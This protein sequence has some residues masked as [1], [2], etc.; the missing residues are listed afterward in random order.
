MTPVLAPEAEVAGLAAEEERAEAAPVTVHDRRADAAEE[1][2]RDIAAPEPP[3]TE[4]PRTEPPPPRP[5]APVPERR[6]GGAVG[7]ILGGIVAGAIGFG[8]AW[9]LERMNDPGLDITGEFESRDAL[10]AA[11]EA[12][13][14]DLRAATADGPDLTPLE[15]ATESAA[16]EAAA[17]RAAV[18]ELRGDIAESVGSL[19]DGL[20][21]LD[22]RLTDLEQLPQGDGSLSSAAVEAYEREIAALRE[23]TAEAVSGLEARAGA[24]ETGFDELRT[25]VEAA[26]AD[27]EAEAEA[28]E[29]QSEEA[30]AAAAART[31]LAEIQGAVSGGAPYADALSDLQASGAVEVPEV[32][33]ANAEAGVASLPALRETFPEA[34]RAALATVRAGESGGGLGGFL[35]RQLNVRSVE[36]REGDDPDAVLSR[37]GAAVDAGR[38]DHAL[39]ELAALPEAAAA[40]L[41]DWTAAATARVEAQD[42]ID[43][44]TQTLTT[45]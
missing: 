1:P 9:Y 10:I 42:A 19:Q 15:T 23:E 13:L 22:T 5:P 16:S 38:I 12:E 33:A 44:L 17:S 7:L 37:A 36:P 39:D 31:A 25:T 45:N 30:A 8:A 6:R 26:L 43:Q 20:A 32:L 11:L 27:L 18:E 35:E 40:A 29:Q 3:R 2:M 28:L 4:P 24:I 21:A 41:S 34:A 14:A